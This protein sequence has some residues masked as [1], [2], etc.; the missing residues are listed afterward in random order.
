MKEEVEFRENDSRV[1][2]LG[3]RK[4][5]I[6]AESKIC[7]SVEKGVLGTDNLIEL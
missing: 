5:Q 3:H 6:I 4:V 1:P 2:F 7:L